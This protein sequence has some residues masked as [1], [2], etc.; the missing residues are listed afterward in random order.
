MFVESGYRNNSTISIYILK[1]LASV[2]QLIQ[3]L[4]HQR[5]VLSRYKALNRTLVEI[6]V[7]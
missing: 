6:H 2:Y 5:L 4:H 1:G 3:I 7:I